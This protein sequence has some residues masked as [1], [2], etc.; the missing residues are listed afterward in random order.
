MPLCP[1]ILHPTTRLAKGTVL[2]ALIIV[3]EF[4]LR[5]SMNQGGLGDVGDDTFIHYT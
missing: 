1:V 4:M 3:L 2:V 5:K